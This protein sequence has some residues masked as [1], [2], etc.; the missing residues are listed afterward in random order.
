[1]QALDVG[2][3]VSIGSSFRAKIGLFEEMTIIVKDVKSKKEKL[4]EML[5]MIF[6]ELYSIL[7]KA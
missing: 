4:Q 6:K 1:M 5:V 7:V 2:W 3:N